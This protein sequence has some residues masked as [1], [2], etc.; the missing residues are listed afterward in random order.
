MT[1]G[2]KGLHNVQDALNR[3]PMK[4]TILAGAG[5]L[6]A[7]GLMGCAADAGPAAPLED[8]PAASNEEE[9][10]TARCPGEVP[11]FEFSSFK[12][13]TSLSGEPYLASRMFNRVAGGA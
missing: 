7:C 5:V 9:V 1:C 2:C 13:R 11:D 3:R 6:V 12:A 8:D 10:R 4:T